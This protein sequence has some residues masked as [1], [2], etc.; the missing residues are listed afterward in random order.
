MARS[1]TAVPMR[2]Q[3]DDPEGLG[4]EPL[5]HRVLER[6]ERRRRVLPLQLMVQQDAAPQ[7]QRQRDRMVGDLGRAVIGHVADQDVAR[8]GGGAVELVIADPH[9][10]DR[11]QPR[12]A[13]QIGA[14]DAKP[15]DHQPVSFGAIG[16]GELRERRGI[17]LHDLE[18]GAENLGFEIVGLLA[19]LGIEHGDGH[20]VSSL[21]FQL[22]IRPRHPRESGGPGQRR[23]LRPWI[24]AFAGMTLI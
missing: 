4:P 23:V 22:V 15:H 11:A 12:K 18:I 24:P 2:P 21:N 20:R 9:A 17:P 13:L 6:A 7:G 14:G 19:G 3:P 1:A 8:R 10:H 16:I 5:D